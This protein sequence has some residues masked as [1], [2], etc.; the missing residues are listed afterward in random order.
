MERWM[1]RSRRRF[2]TL[3][4]A[5]SAAAVTTPVADLASAAAP[6]KRA[7]PP[8]TASEGR[9]ADAGR[10]PAVAD[11]IRKQKAVV[12]QS[13]KAVRD[14]PLPPGSEPAFVF[15]PL[16]PRKPTDAP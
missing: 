2:L 9:E 8:K 16:K 7:T 11:E 6:R 10:P 3:L 15:A 1:K 13:L 4:A 14:Y 12:E 5:G